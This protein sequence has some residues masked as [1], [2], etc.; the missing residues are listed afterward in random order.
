MDDKPDFTAITGDVSER[1]SAPAPELTEASIRA[2]AIAHAIKLG[3]CPPIG[4]IIGFNVQMQ[5]G[6]TSMLESGDFSKAEN[7]SGKVPLQFTVTPEDI[8]LAR[9]LIRIGENNLPRT[10]NFRHAAQ[11]MNW[12]EQ[13]E[14]MV[15]QSTK[16]AAIE[17]L[18]SSLDAAWMKKLLQMRPTNR[19]FLMDQEQSDASAAHKAGGGNP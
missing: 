7:V 10:E 5:R 8:A 11:E 4:A 14:K 18:V 17:A 12:P 13:I 9:A 2:G 1:C 19:A 16:L 15:N 3:K 6:D